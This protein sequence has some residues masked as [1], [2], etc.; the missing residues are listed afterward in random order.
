VAVVLSVPVGALLL[1]IAWKIVWA[2]GMAV[3]HL[4]GR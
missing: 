2:V 3:M 1:Y 4:V